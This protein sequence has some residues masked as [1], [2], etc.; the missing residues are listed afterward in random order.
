MIIP[1]NDDYRVSSDAMNW[2]V[3][4]R[5]KHNWRAIGWYS[6][7]GA[8]AKKLITYQL[9]TSDVVGLDAALNELDRLTQELTAALRPC[10]R[11]NVE[12]IV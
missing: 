9:M 10:L 6:T 4:K 11:L 8:A 7:P 2:K 1:I 12:D 5:E 3:E